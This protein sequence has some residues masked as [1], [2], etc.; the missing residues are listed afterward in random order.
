MTTARS[1]HLRRREDY[2]VEVGKGAALVVLDCR[3]VC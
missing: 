3:E 2:G 1:V